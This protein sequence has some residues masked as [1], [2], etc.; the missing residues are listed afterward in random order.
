MKVLVH[1]VEVK[2]RP[3]GSVVVS[4]T[5]KCRVTGVPVPSKRVS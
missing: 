1:L 4:M 2:V 3:V 5:M